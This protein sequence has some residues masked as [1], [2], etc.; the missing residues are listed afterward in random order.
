[1]R[2]KIILITLLIVILIFSVFTTKKELQQRQIAVTEAEAFAQSHVSPLT[3][4]HNN[5]AWRCYWGCLGRKYYVKVR[6][7]A[8]NADYSVRVWAGGGEAIFA[9]N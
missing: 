3:L 7:K 2:R 1:M 5:S 6:A 8:N 9:Q 4:T